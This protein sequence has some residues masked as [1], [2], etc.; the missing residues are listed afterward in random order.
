MEQPISMPPNIP[1][2]Q[3]KITTCKLPAEKCPLSAV[4]QL[5]NQEGELFGKTGGQS[6]TAGIVSIG[7]GV[8]RSGR[9]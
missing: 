7:L 6:Y 3:H 8:F 1:N 2:F 4:G 9:Y 5:Q